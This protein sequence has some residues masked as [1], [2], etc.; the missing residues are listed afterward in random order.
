[1]GKKKKKNQDRHIIALNKRARHYYE[2]V[3]TIEAGIVLTGSEV[4]SL[5]QGQ[6]SLSDAYAEIRG[7]EVYLVNMHIA[8]YLH[9]GVLNHEP[10]RDRKLLLHKQEIKRL[11]G[12]VSQKGYTLI[13]LSLYFKKGFVKV[14]LALAKGKSARDRREEIRRRDEKRIL[15]RE[16]RL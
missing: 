5:R 8:P 9:A 7:G 10:K 11:T 13:P 1:M 4:R 2:I 15:E 14:E 12:K 3:D 6:V 16:M